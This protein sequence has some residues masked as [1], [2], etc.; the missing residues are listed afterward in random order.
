MLAIANAPR[1][2]AHDA[3]LTLRAA[4]DKFVPASTTSPAWPTAR[5]LDLKQMSP[6]AIESLWQEAK[7]M[8]R[9]TGAR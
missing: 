9:R 6:A 5:G 3:E 7:E 4:C 8:T 1:F 2:I